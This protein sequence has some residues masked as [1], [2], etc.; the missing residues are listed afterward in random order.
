M[1]ELGLLLVD[2][3]DGLAGLLR[4]G[5]RVRGIS[6]GGLLGRRGLLRGLREGRRRRGERRLEEKCEGARNASWWFAT[7]ST[8][9]TT[10]LAGRGDVLG[11]R[12]VDVRHGVGSRGWVRPL[13]VLHETGALM[14][15]RLCS[16]DGVG[17]PERFPLRGIDSTNFRNSTLKN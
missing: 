14:A 4:G 9:S 7:P 17:S 11:R 12:E 15:A 3:L 1:L 2:L 13:R 16:G 5:R 6:E 10:H 8:A